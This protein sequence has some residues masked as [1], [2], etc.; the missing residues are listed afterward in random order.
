MDVDQFL[1]G[2]G[3]LHQRVVGGRHLAEAA[4]DQQDKVRLLHARRQL[5]VEADADVAGVVFVAMIE[6]HL[7]AEGASD[8]QRPAFGYALH[9][10]NRLRGPARAAED[11]ERLL[12]RIEQRFELIQLRLA[13]P[14]LDRGEGQGGRC[15]DCVGQHVFRQRD[16]HRAGASG[17]GDCE[18]T[19]DEFGNASGVLDLHHPFGDV[20]EE[21]VI[22][23]FLER[24]TIL[25]MRGDLA[26]E[27]D[28]RNGI[29]HG[30]VDAGRGVGGAGAARDE[31]DAGP[32]GE[33]SFAI[34][35]HGGAAFLAADD[36]VDGG[37]V[38]R[39]E[40]GEIGFARHAEHALDAVGFQRLDDQFS[41]GLHGRSFSSSARISAVCS[42]RRGEGRS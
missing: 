33:P 13:R 6:Q 40:H 4:A 24:L 2:V 29:L 30:D 28:H 16:D 25:R 8:R 5:R 15:L 42:P 38:Q 17:G 32:A 9:L 11:G 31:A 35:H 7:A 10:L 12:R 37:I 19:G 14:R 22:V 20:A 39:V 41:A 21:G 3:A 1:V 26:D 27:Q 34:G 18:G 23:D 36:G